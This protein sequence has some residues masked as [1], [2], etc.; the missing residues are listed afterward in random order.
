MH[1][2]ASQM[3][4]C[5]RVAVVVTKMDVHNQN[6][7][8]DL[9]ICQGEK[10]LSNFIMENKTREQTDETENNERELNRKA[11]YQG[12]WF[13]LFVFTPP[14]PWDGGTA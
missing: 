4:N 5:E 11:N 9:S 3:N 6:K 7:N 8:N 10:V 12:K 14:L 1:C 13:C 2:E